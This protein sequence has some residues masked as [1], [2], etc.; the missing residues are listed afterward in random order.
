MEYLP[1][2]GNDVEGKVRSSNVMIFKGGRLILDTSPHLDNEEVHKIQGQF[3]QTMKG[4]VQGE[5]SEYIYIKSK[6][7]NETGQ[8][9]GLVVYSHLNPSESSLILRTIRSL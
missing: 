2:L 1:D 3:S 7:G 8:M 4:R 6:D 5:A 9:G